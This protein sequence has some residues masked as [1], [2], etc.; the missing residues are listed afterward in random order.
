MVTHFSIF[1]FLLQCSTLRDSPP[2]LPGKGTRLIRPGLPIQALG[3]P[4]LPVRSR[5]QCH[6]HRSMLLGLARA[7]RE[8]PLGKPNTIS[9]A[10]ASEGREG[11]LVAQLGFHREEITAS[12]LRTSPSYSILAGVVVATLSRLSLSVLRAILTLSLLDFSAKPSCL[13]EATY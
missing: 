12:L 5:P 10:L 7:M 6:Y 4:E 13:Q 1:H 11:A 2:A 8:T 3:Y 9:I